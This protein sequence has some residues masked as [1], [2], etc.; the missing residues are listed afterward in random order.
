MMKRN[1]KLSKLS[2]ISYKRNKSIN[3]NKAVFFDRDGTLHID[4]VMTYKIEDLHL[5][6]DTQNI[7]K[8]F[9]N[10]GYLIIVITNQSGIRLG[11][12]T[13]QQMQLFNLHLIRELEHLDCYIDAIYYSPFCET[14]NAISFKPNTGMIQR[15]II[16]YNLNINECILIGDKMTDIRAG[17]NAGISENYLVTTGIYENNDYTTEPYFDEYKK[18]THIVNC[19]NDIIKK[20]KN[21]MF[22]SF[23]FIFTHPYPTGQLLTN[24]L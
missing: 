20:D 3:T 9:Q 11:K 8:Y 12:Y 22:L 13:K 6:N 10:K 1:R 23:I 17:F 21:Y 4:K 16:E 24:F 2:K 18:K 7:I 15:A 14:D 19:L 5:F